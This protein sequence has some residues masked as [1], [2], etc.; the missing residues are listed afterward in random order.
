MPAALRHH[1]H[2]IYADNPLT[3]CNF[4]QLNE[5]CN[6]NLRWWRVFRIIKYMTTLC[7]FK[8]ETRKKRMTERKEKECFDWL[9]RRTG[10]YAMWKRSNWK[11]VKKGNDL[12]I[13]T[14]KLF[15]LR[16]SCFLFAAFS[17]MCF[18]FTLHDRVFLFEHKV[19][20]H[21]KKAQCNEEILF[22]RTLDGRVYCK[23]LLILTK[24]DNWRT[25]NARALKIWNWMILRFLHWVHCQKSALFWKN[26]NAPC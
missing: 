12:H 14:P 5:H 19:D 23:R 7:S 3:I 20:L 18:C 22:T 4:S 9:V 8:N 17:S 15:R 16:R 21:I 25:E 1:H 6:K 26:K 10:F 11:Q 24:F 2:R 13:R